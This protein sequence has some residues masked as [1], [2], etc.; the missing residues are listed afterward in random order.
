MQPTT[1]PTTSDTTRRMQR[2]RYEFVLEAA[3]PIAHLAEN[4]GNE[5]VLMRRKVRTAD[6]SF[7]SVPMVTADTM[8]HGMREAAAYM[9]LDAAGLLEQ[10]KLSENAI[11]LLFAGGMVR[12]KGSDSSSVRLDEYRKLCELVPALE[13]F[14]GCAQNRVIPG[15]L[16]VDDATVICDETERFVPERVMAWVREQRS[17]IG[18]ARE[19]VEEVQRVRM[20]P[21]LR[22]SVVQMLDTGD[23]VRLL[24]KANKSEAAAET[25]NAIERA[26]TKSAMMPRRFER[27]VQGALFYWGCEAT[28]YTELALD[29]FRLA[30][31]AFLARAKVGGK[32]GT[33]HG[34]LRAIM[35]WDIALARPRDTITHADLATLAPRV[36]EVFRAHVAARKAEIASFLGTVDA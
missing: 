8:R 10:N 5:G 27:I 6:G 25:H 7:A 24:D 23:Q 3:Q 28:V 14:G 2:H 1:Q 21:M 19:H 17:A 13:L 35:S 18:T 11:R 4:I 29:T 15:Y 20:D 34:Q 22:P 36:G 32:R 9:F 33:G 12:G 31:M 16:E 26:A 30:A